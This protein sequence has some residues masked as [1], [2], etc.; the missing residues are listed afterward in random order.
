MVYFIGDD[1]KCSIIWGRDFNT[2]LIMINDNNFLMVFARN[3][4]GLPMICA[5]IFIPSDSYKE[6]QFMWAQ[7]DTTLYYQIFQ[8]CHVRHIRNYYICGTEKN[9]EISYIMQ[10]TFN[11]LDAHPSTWIQKGFY[12]D[13]I[14]FKNLCGN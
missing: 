10:F 11:Y 1:Y 12:W 13:I 8:L 7:I 2:W 14:L 5:M 6:Q 9:C 4:I 3:V